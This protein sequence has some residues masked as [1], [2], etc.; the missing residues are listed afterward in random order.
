M[1][2]KVKCAGIYKISIGDFYYIGKSVDTFSRW[3]SHYTLLKLN[4][5]HSPEL[6]SKFNELGVASLT[7]SIL[8][9]V[10]LTEYKKEHQ[11]KGKQLVKSFNTFLLSREKYHMSNHS[12]NFSLNKDKKYF[13]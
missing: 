1:I 12:I 5:H 3:S 6:Q 4:K 11:I 8:E 2:Q 10:S 13:K 9:Y 7:F